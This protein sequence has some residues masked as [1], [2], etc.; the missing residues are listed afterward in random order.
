M[1]TNLDETSICAV[2]HRPIDVQE[3]GYCEEHLP[4]SIRLSQELSQVYGSCMRLAHAE[5]MPIGHSQELTSIA[6]RIDGIC[7]DLED[8]TV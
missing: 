7:D 8:V 1:S 2:C 4:A 5:G 3:Q 6:E